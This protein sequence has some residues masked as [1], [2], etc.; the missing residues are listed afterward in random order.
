[1]TISFTEKIQ[2]STRVSNSTD[3]GL[4]RSLK[5]GPLK[6]TRRRDYQANTE[7]SHDVA[8][9]KEIIAQLTFDPFPRYD[10]GYGS[11]RDTLFATRLNDRFGDN[12]GTLAG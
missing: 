3:D 9:L 4:K 8:T 11:R 12:D 6:I 10:N 2:N 7:K 5:I 1:M